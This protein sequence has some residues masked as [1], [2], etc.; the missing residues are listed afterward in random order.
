MSLTIINDGEERVIG[1][2]PDKGFAMI[3]QDRYEGYV[4][5]AK[6]I[7]FLDDLAAHVTVGRHVDSQ[8]ATFFM[9]SFQDEDTG[10]AGA[11]YGD[12]P[13]DAIERARHC[14]AVRKQEVQ[15]C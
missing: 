8:G 1:G 3:E 10:L 6:L 14:L 5:A 11:E 12:K 2:A 4:R 13:S 9:C 7:N 15:R